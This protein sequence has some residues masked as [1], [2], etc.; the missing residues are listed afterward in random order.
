MKFEQCNP[1]VRYCDIIKTD[2]Y[3]EPELFLKSYDNCM[4]YLLS[5]AIKIC[6]ENKTYDLS[7]GD[8]LFWRAGMKYSIISHEIKSSYILVNFD[9]TERRKSSFN[10]KIPPETVE[11]FDEE[12]ITDKTSFDDIK[13]FNFCVYSPQK[14]MLEE[15]FLGLYSDYKIKRS[16]LNLRLKAR[17]LLV[18]CEISNTFS[19]SLSKKSTNLIDEVLSYVTENCM[20]P[21]I[22]NEHIAGKFGFHPRHINRL[23]NQK[24]GYSLHKLIVV[25]RVQKAGDL[26]I[27]SKRPIS[28]IA[29]QVGFNNIHHF[30]RCFK[31]H[32][33]LSPAKYRLH[34]NK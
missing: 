3:P 27:N 26:L 6:V 21:S 4:I 1:Y 8:I 24:T 9:F 17:I 31:K 25:K 34:N 14:N 7:H 10:I 16:Y 12:K 11:K 13:E 15:N 29:I 23:I 2:L 22:S 19:Y 20:D 33:G 32:M 18:L 30:S 5:G 28:E